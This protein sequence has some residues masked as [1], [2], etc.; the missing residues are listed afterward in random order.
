MSTIEIPT[1]RQGP[2]AITRRAQE[3]IL[4]VG[5]A[6]LRLSLEEAWQLAESLGPAFNG[7]LTPALL[8]RRSRVWT[9]SASAGAQM[10]SS[11]ML[12]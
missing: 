8:P 12:R 4:T 5:G 11:E 3:V 2:I 1:E 6:E 9:P 7:S 10:S